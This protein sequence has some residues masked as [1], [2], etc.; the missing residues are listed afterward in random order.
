MTPSPC[1]LSYVKNEFWLNF[2]KNVPRVIRKH[3]GPR[4]AL[5]K[6]A[7]II[8]FG[9]APKEMKEKH[10]RPI[11]SP[12]SVVFFLQVAWFATLPFFPRAP[13]TRI[14]FR[15]LP[16]SATSC[17]FPDWLAGYQ[18]VISYSTTPTSD[19]TIWM[20]WFSVELWNF[21]KKF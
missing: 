17:D 2:G 20:F 4:Q 3:L 7:K 1:R 10:L 15:V 12:R 5:M 6:S 18:S 19:Q 8:S 11:Q 16:S 9:L 21:K 13:R 14:P